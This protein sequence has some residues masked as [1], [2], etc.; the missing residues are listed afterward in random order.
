MIVSRLA[1]RLIAD[2]LALEFG[3]RRARWR[4]QT[5]RPTAC[6]PQGAVIDSIEPMVS[7][8]FALIGKEER[9]CFGDAVSL[10]ALASLDIR[11]GGDSEERCFDVACAQLR[12][13]VALARSLLTPAEI[14][15]A[16]HVFADIADKL[17][18]LPSALSAHRL[19]ASA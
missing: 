11:F 3:L 14:I 5:E 2:L 16:D 13:D 8:L 1:T 19:G 15:L 4:W 9:R 12:D 18:N 10:Y 6:P 7:A 17:E